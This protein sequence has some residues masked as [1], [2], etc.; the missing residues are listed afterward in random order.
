MVKSWKTSAV[1]GLAFIG[2]AYNI[3]TNGGISVTDFLLLLT[4]IGFLFTKDSNVTHSGGVKASKRPD[5]IGGD[6][7]SEGERD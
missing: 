7:P 6:G 2:L 3:Y 5:T 1:A 4:G